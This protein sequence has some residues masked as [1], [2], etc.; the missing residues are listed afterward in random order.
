M[1]Q[2]S[3]VAAVALL[4]TSLLAACGGS[5]V[6]L[7]RTVEGKVVTQ[8]EAAGLPLSGAEPKRGTATGGETVTSEVVVGGRG[9][10]GPTTGK[11]GGTAAAPGGA[12]TAAR[13]NR[14]S[15]RGVTDTSIKIGVISVLSGGQRFVGEPPYRTAVAYAEDLNRR[16]G[17]N[18]RKVEV[19]GYDVCLSCPE[20][21]L[22]VAK[23]AVE[24]DHVYAILNAFVANASMGP[25][26]QYLAQN[27]TPMIQTSSAGPVNPWAFAF[28][29]KLPNRGAVDADYAY[30]Y[31]V[32]HKLP[33]KVALLRFN[34]PIDAEVSHWQRVGLQKRGIEVV[35]EEAVEYGAGMTNQGSQTAKMQQAG[36][37][38]IVGSHGVV[39]AFNMSSAG[40]RGWNVPYL[41]TI[42]YDQY[43]QDLAGD[44]MYKR[45]VLCDSDGYATPDMPGS[46]VAA[47]NRVMGT[48]YPDYDVG[49]LTLYSFLGMKVLEDGVAPMGD[50]V[51]RDGLRQY[52]SGLKAYDGGG[53]VPPFTVTPTDHTAI[54]GAVR[55]KLG[56]DGFWVRVSDGFVFP[57]PV[58]GL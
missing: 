41:C 55:L 8:E 47:Y 15:D 28:G 18:G 36:A 11:S 1:R 9:G 43:A 44:E 26:M 39:C 48:Y 12:P 25:A 46:G 27:Q 57:K 2:R 50:N 3:G 33:L 21:G 35:D 38:L 23:K 30:D 32:E 10:V 51:T 54:A 29:M 7:R 56:K 45:D 24:Q 20:D 52:L 22:A 5:G 34:T 42:L 6:S 16:G 19:I 13:G 58:H 40:Q 53:L 4:V 37:Q 14:T 49:L 31:L 17:I